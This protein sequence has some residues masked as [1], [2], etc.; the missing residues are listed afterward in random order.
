MTMRALVYDRY[1]APDVLRLSEL[2]TPTP[3]TGQVVVRVCACGLNSADLRLLKGEPFVMRLMGYGLF[4]PKYRVLGSDIAGR[5]EQV[6]AGV[7]AFKVGD[8]VYGDLS[9]CGLGGLAEYVA[10]P[11][12]ALAPM[13]PSLSFEQAA[14]VP[15]GALTALQALRDKGAVKAGE[16]VAINGAAGGVGTFAVQIAVAMGA[17]VTAVAS[18]GNL[19]GLRALGAAHVVDYARED[20]T[21]RIGE[22]DVILGVNGYHPLAHYGRA[23]RAGGRYVMVG[24][25]DG[26]LFEGLAR[27]PFMPKRDGKRFTNLTASTSVED[28]RAVSAMIERGVVRPVVEQVVGLAEAVEGF[29]QLATGRARGKRVVS[30]V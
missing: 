29:R 3:K 17:E 11:E 18:A 5:V 14:A 22:Y 12:A 10:V 19:D 27:A 30:L 6:G 15:M 21:E 1:G 2:P 16:R 9:G 23:L 25:S 8:A 4:R 28:L 20:F 13:P 26:Q 7:T 24:G